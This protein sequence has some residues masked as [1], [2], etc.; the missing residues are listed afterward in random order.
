[1][2][3]KSRCS[4][5]VM[6][7][8]A[9]A[10]PHV[11]KRA[12]SHP[13]NR[14]TPPPLARLAATRRS[15]SVVRRGR[16]FRAGSALMSR[17]SRS[18]VTRALPPHQSVWCL[19]HRPLP[20]AAVNT[21][22]V[23]QLTSGLFSTDESVETHRRFQRWVTRVSHGLCSPFKVPLSPHLLEPPWTEV[24]DHL[25]RRFPHWQASEASTSAFP[26]WRAMMVRAAV[27]LREF[28]TSPRPPTEVVTA[29]IVLPAKSV[30]K[31]GS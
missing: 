4:A 24:L 22:L 7:R 27:S 6:L 8:S 5:L 28:P 23:E 1:M 26:S 11:T 16:P 19:R 30:R 21:A 17:A 18:C 31:Q 12:S 15:W 14:L 9:E 20:D 25:G 13:A 29:D 2:E 10:D 3:T